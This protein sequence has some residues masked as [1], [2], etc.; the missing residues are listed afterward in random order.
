MDNLKR[1]EP[2]NL[3]IT[4]QGF[5][6][7]VFG[8]TDCLKCAN[9]CRTTSPIFYRKDIEKAAKS[10][11]LKPA[12]FIDKFLKVDE[13]NDFVVK[14]APCPF[15]LNDNYCAIYEHRPVACRTYPHT[16]RKRFHQLLD[17]TYQNSFI[18]PA[19]QN[20]IEKLQAAYKY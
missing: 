20:I 8:K 14:S 2:S 19:V 6:A 10:L 18:C 12:A 13:D 16:D 15:L 5:H 4:V 17:L 11:S 1:R 3:D 9:C 7:E